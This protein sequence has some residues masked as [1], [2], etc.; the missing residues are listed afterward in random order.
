MTDPDEP[1]PVYRW[2]IVQ[3]DGRRTEFVEVEDIM[4]CIKGPGDYGHC[5]VKGQSE[6]STFICDFE[7]LFGTKEQAIKTWIDEQQRVVDAGLKEIKRA[8]LLL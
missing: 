6:G 1:A 8:Q 3:Q 4:R 5:C 7:H 2:A